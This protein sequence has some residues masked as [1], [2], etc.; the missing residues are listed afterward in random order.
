MDVFKYIL[1]SKLFGH[2]SFSDSIYQPLTLMPCCMISE[3]LL[4]DWKRPEYTFIVCSNFQINFSQWHKILTDTTY[5]IASSLSLPVSRTQLRHCLQKTLIR[6][7][8]LN[9]K[10]FYTSIFRAHITFQGKCTHLFAWCLYLKWCLQTLSFPRY[11]P[12]LSISEVT[13]S[14][15]KKS[16]VCAPKF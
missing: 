11:W 14:S 13:S 6:W 1:F 2:S 15:R 8:K 16:R 9:F 4:I 7:E 12:K 5:N 10:L 3:V